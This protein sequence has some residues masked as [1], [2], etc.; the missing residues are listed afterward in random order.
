MITPP[1][2]TAAS[3]ACAL[4]IEHMRP[5]VPRPLFPRAARRT[6][7]SYII[8]LRKSSSDIISAL[9]IR[10]PADI[11]DDMTCQYAVRA[12]TIFPITFIDDSRLDTPAHYAD[13]A[14]SGAR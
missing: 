5:A 8:P 10:A 3:G 11:T 6:S 9:F 13:A 2:F 4:I 1:I 7:D 12:I 14:A